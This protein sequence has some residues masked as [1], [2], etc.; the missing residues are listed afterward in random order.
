MAKLGQMLI[1]SKIITDGQ[2]SQA[3][4]LQKKSGG[5]LGTSLVKLGYITEE[6]LVAFLSKQFEI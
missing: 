4:T 1:T 6:K 3:L 5:R 2:L